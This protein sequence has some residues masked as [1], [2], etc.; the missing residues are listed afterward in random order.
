MNQMKI[1]QGR[2]GKR[3]SYMGETQIIVWNRYSYQVSDMF[4]INVSTNE[5]QKFYNSTVQAL[6]RGGGDCATKCVSLCARFIDVGARVK[7]Q[8]EN[9]LSKLF[10]FWGQNIDT[11]DRDIFTLKD[12][13][14]HD[15]EGKKINTSNPLTA[16]Q[17]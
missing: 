2:N 4:V 6:S 15:E 1:I 7:S 5:N 8:V 11:S 17:R 14:F 13:G 9:R 10:D 12:L 3:T 16:A